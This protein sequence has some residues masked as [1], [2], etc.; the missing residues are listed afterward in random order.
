MTIVY[1]R[2]E[3]KFN[4]GDQ[5]LH[6]TGHTAHTIVGRVW[7][8]DDIAWVYVAT[9]GM[10][11]AVMAVEEDLSPA[12]VTAQAGELTYSVERG[13]SNNWNLYMRRPHEATDKFLGVI[14]DDYLAKIT[15]G[16]LNLWLR[17]DG[18]DDD[19]LWDITDV[20]P[21]ARRK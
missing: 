19:V 3:P 9:A 12:A 14:F 6:M 8:V 2:P 11:A 7:S 20:L 21:D 4:V 5:V 17:T 15:V 1:E 18:L 10:H 16:W 13:H